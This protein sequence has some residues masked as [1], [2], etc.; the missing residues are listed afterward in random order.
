ML[1]EIEDEEIHR[2]REIFALFDEDGSGSITINELGN[3][4]RALGHD[5]SEIELSEMMRD[6][7]LN[8]DNP[9]W[10]CI[11]GY[12]YIFVSGKGEFWLCSMERK[13]GINILDVTPEM[14]KDNNKKK[15]C[16]DRCGVY[17]VVTESLANN[18]PIRFLGSEISGYVSGIPQRLFNK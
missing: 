17:C 1:F 11:A 9:D 7:D 2:I 18:N 8:K 12:K 13:P 14:L 3:I 15:W 5:F 16:Q 6:T 10:I 4:Y